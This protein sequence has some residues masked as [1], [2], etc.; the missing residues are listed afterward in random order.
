M[1]SRCKYCN[2]EI[3]KVRQEWRT[4]VMYLDA[5]GA[6]WRYS[7]DENGYNTHEPNET[8]EVTQTLLKYE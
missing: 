2:R 7:C 1:T 4:N 3:I 6:A 5:V 8:Y